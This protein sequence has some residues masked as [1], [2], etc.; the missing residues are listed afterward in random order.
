MPEQDPA[1]RQA[2]APLFLRT[3]RDLP[4][5]L[6]SEQAVLGAILVEE[7]AFDQVA[8]MLKAEDFYLLAHQHVYATCEELARESKTLDPIIVQ[9]RLDAKGLLGSAVPR[10]L[11]LSLGRAIGTTANVTH[12]ARSILELARL[13]RMMLVAQ[14]VVERGYE[15]GANVQSFLDGAQQD[16]FTAA[17][18]VGIETLKE[19]KEPV[20]RALDNLEAVQKRVMAGLSPITGVATGIATLDKNTLGLQPGALVVLA[21]RPSVGKTAFALNIATHAATRAGKKVAFFSLEMPSEQLALRMLASE[22]KLDWRR[23]SQGQLSSYDWQ[24]IQTH[25]DR[26][27]RASV[28]LDDNFV[29]TP[30]ELRSKCRKLKRE[31]GGLDLVVVDYL[32]LM[33]APSDRPN[34]SREQEIATISRSLKSLAKEIECPILALSQL[35]RSVEKRKGEPPMLSDLRESGAI[36]QDADVVMFLHRNEDDSKE[37]Q[38]GATATDTLEVQLIV[39]K[40][41]QGPTCSIPLVFFKTTTFF[42]EMERRRDG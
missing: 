14:G 36:E 10:E 11:P 34:Q 25:G 9:Q 24:K 33:H 30:V 23:L 27:A 16:V 3:A 31:N 38:A 17:A 20:L 1:R 18:G 29:L 35:N 7:T 37:A 40:Q 22:A 6:E 42:A 41:R 28:W 2:E 15:A 39:A 12:Y 19:I 5:S 13:R 21:A 8:A 4:H 32:Q 26:I